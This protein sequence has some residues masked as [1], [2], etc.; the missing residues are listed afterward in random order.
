MNKKI[1]TA[2]GRRKSSVAQVKM[3]PGNGK[4]IVNG[5]DVSEYLPFEVLVM[6][7]KQ[8]LV[9]TNNESTFDITV[10]VRGGGYSGQTGAI[11]LAI[12]KALLIY[13]E[14]TDASSETSYRRVLKE[15]GLVTRD[16]RVKERKKYGLKKAR[17]APQ[18]SKR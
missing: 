17:R 13:D 5:K 14:G 8:P 10:V 12:T 18:F 4:I 3:V 6:D 16:P 15:A 11:R 9:L 1:I 2:S 7:L